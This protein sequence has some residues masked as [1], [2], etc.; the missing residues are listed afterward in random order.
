MGAGIALEFKRRFPAMFHA[1]RNACDAGEVRP[2]QMH[3]FALTGDGNPRYIINFPTK[4]HWRDRSRLEDVRSGL[5]ALVEEVQRLGI[6]S[7]AVPALGC[8][9]GG[10]DWKQVRPLI[11][12]AFTDAPE[13]HV[14]LFR[15]QGQNS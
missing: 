14:L 2:G 10:L 4:R 13:V 12:S 5:P 8:G 7:I 15:P 6:H 11:E 1:Y 9:H 3:I